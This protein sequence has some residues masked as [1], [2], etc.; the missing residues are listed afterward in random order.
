MEKRV[1]FDDEGFKPLLHLVIKADEVNG[2]KNFRFYENF[3]LK[4]DWPLEKD[5]V[6][7]KEAVCFFQAV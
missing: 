7:H 4:R 6:D 5:G 3:C 2:F 1:E